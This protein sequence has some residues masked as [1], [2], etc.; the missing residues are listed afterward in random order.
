MSHGEPWRSPESWTDIYY[1]TIISHS[2]KWRTSPESWHLSRVI[3][4][5]LSNIH[6]NT[7]PGNNCLSQKALS[8]GVCLAREKHPLQPK[9][10]LA[11]GM[12]R[13]GKAPTSGSP[14]VLCPCGTQGFGNIPEDQPGLGEIPYMTTVSSL[15]TNG[16]LF[17]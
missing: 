13:P 3:I 9:G 5:Q 2:H 12:S 11:R 7:R 6:I 14:E 17:P 4:M 1:N 10:T 15:C 8:P 16:V